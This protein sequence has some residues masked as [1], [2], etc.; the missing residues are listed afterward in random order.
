MRSRMKWKALRLCR[1][2][3]ICGTD[4]PANGDFCCIATFYYVTCG[5]MKLLEAEVNNYDRQRN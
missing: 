5:V 1:F 4:F 3:I 2:P